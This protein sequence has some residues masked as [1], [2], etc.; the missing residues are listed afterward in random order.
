MASFSASIASIIVEASSVSAN[1]DLLEERLLTI[2]T[3]CV[4]EAF[5]TSLARDELLWQ[6]WTVLG[7]N[8]RQLRD[9]TH[10]ASILQSVQQYRTLAS[11]YITATVHALTVVDADLT[12]FREQLCMHTVG[13]NSLPVEVHIKSLE[14]SLNRLKSS[15]VGGK[16]LE[17]EV[18]RVYELSGVLRT[19]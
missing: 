19:E 1:L 18:A 16:G 2:H 6:L 12:E 7:G 8:R 11:A 10:R 9:L 3:L 14:G 13:T 17:G 15:S 4:H 5:D